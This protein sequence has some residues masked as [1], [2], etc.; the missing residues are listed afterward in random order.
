MARTGH[1]CRN[2]RLADYSEHPCLGVPQPWNQVSAQEANKQAEHAPLDIESEIR[3][4]N[5]CVA[6]RLCRNRHSG[7]PE[8]VAAHAVGDKAHDREEVF[9]VIHR[10]GRHGATVDEVAMLLDRSPN[11]ISGRFSELKAQGRIVK[12]GTRRSTRTRA[13]AAVCIAIEGA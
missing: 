12:T 1:L 5:L 9:G 8:S 3:V 6:F 4:A 7:N 13:S 2:H 11:Q 10:L